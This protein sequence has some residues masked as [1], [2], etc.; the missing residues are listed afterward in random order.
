ML[1]LCHVLVTEGLHD[2]AFLERC[3]HGADRFVAYVLGASDGVAKTPEWAQ[4][5]SGLPANDL[6]EL[7]RQMAASR[8]LVTVSY[9][10]QRAE[11]GE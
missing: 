3:C 9:S 7:A 10:L 11:H 6:R 4:A 1:A 8:T 5:L 2:E